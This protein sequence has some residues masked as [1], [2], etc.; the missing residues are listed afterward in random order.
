MSETCAT[1]KMSELKLADNLMIN[2]TADERFNEILI[3]EAGKAEENGLEP[4]VGNVCTY[5]CRSI[6]RLLLGDELFCKD[7]AGLDEETA[8]ALMRKAG[9]D[10]VTKI[11][12]GGLDAINEDME[13]EP[14]DEQ[15]D[16]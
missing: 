4:T 1:E 5:V 3:Q 2:L 8:E 7:L 12:S 14:V 13:N 6:I 16:A 10:I 15:D 9:D 11:R